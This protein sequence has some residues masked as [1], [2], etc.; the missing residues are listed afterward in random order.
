MLPI[1][2]N[3]RL[4][5]EIIKS[6]I[7][8]ANFSNSIFNDIIGNDSSDSPNPLEKNKAIDLNSLKDNVI[9]IRKFE[10][11]HDGINKMCDIFF[12]ADQSVICGVFADKGQWSVVNS[13]TIQIKFP[14]TDEY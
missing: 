2:Y 1:A 6:F 5:R 11:R 8:E 14:E 10:L 13:F 4:Y 9:Q 7:N 3:F 12:E